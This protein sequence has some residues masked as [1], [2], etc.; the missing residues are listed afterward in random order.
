MWNGFWKVTAMFGVIGVGLFAVYAAQKGMNLKLPGTVPD[1]AEERA[2]T[3]DTDSS[4]TDD[5]ASAD[6]S[7]D[8]VVAT[9]PEPPKVTSKRRKPIVEVQSDSDADLTPI[10]PAP[11]KTSIA[12]A[13]AER[14]ESAKKTA[15]LEF[16]DEFE[17]AEKE[18]EQLK[19][20]E[21]PASKSLDHTGVK[22][23][24]AA[25]EE[26]LTTTEDLA[27]SSEDDAFPAVEDAV[28]ST[29]ES[30]PPAEIPEPAS[31]SQDT[32]SFDLESSPPIRSKR[33]MQKSEKKSD[34]KMTV[35]STGFG[36]DSLLSK[37]Q[38]G[39]IPASSTTEKDS[40]FPSDRLEQASGSD[41]SS[42]QEPMPSNAPRS[43]PAELTPPVNNDLQ[44]DRSLPTRASRPARMPAELD[45]DSEN[46]P[47]R[48]NRESSPRRKDAEINP[49]EMVG[50]GVA[51][52]PSQ[53]GVQQ[54]RLTIEKIAQPQAVLGQP[55][56]YS[57]II[58]NTG[59]V[60]AYNVVI[61]DRIPKGAKLE[62]TKPQAEMSGGRL[63]W[64][65]PVLKPNESKTISIKV[66]PTQ[67]GP[68]GSVARVHFATEAT[69]EIVVAAPQLKFTVDAPREV[70]IGQKFNLVYNLKNVGRVDASEIVVRD[71]V[72]EELKN[73]AGN[74]IECLIGKLAP[75]ESREIVLPV[76]AE[77][78]GSVIN[79]AILT[80]DGGIKETLESSIEIV[81]EVLVLTRS[82][83]NRLYVERPATFTNN[84]RN[85]GNQR[86][87]KVRISEIVPAGMQFSTASD[88][89]KFD[90]NSGSVVWTLGP[91][92]PGSDKTVNVK[93]V[94]KETGTF[95]AKITATGAAGSTAA[96][97]ASVDVVGK[98]ELQMET[99]SRT[100]E[101]TVGDQ[102]TSKF[103]LNNSGTAVATNVQLKIRLPRELRLIS[104]K[105]GKF[106]QTDD[107]V[108]IFESI[109][110][111][112]PR[113]K[114]AYELVWEP[115][116][117]ADAQIELEISAD[118]L[119]KPGRRIESIQ[120]ARD[121]LK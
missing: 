116:A 82:G 104:V 4:A 1:A 26:T 93:Y 72:P 95:D 69:A 100:G 57:I 3:D 11:K 60:D 31:K 80:G 73:E 79:K 21:P 77:R 66:V 91:L 16:V 62:G 49:A 101:V 37:L 74:D 110:E 10:E 7:A 109:D 48:K 58:K 45:T 54:P 70:R 29:A 35:D 71:L 89:G 24:S 68:I 32:S 2:V 30:T 92:A 18:S 105:G 50:D 20:K 53:R 90:P 84:I 114:I 51:G 9:E 121:P 23:A 98:P 38:P 75:D 81:G 65:Q 102:I 56:V 117:E 41:S 103:Q 40:G 8:D 46:V 55:L 64:N 99:L 14:V 118:H 44:P 12:K 94:P 5:P 97:N 36:D 115:T 67:E 86:A 61:E 27:A 113:T 96:I 33:A 88:G 119:Q 19:A 52:D 76:T 108:V 83:Q 85:A 63:I 78:T 107:D 22:T 43:L 17:A 47:A 15:K 111:F 39:G 42:I 28:T 34:I 120:I 6:P 59:N 87:D 112:A 13:T 106:K 25:I